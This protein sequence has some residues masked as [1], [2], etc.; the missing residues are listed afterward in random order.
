MTLRPDSDISAIRQHI[1]ALRNASWLDRTRQ[2]W[3]T[4]LFHCT[5]ITNV[6]SILSDGEI[7]SRNRITSAGQLPTDIASPQVIEGTNLKWQDYVRLYFRPRTPTQYRNEGFRPIG[8]REW[9]SHCPVPV[10]LIFNALTVLSRSDSWFSDGNLGSPYA[11]VQ[12][13]VA[14]LKQIPFE[15]VYH[16]S[17]FSRS[18]RGRQIV[19]HRHAEVLVPQSMR[20]DS[21]RLIGCRSDAE[22]KTLLQLLPPETHSRWVSRIGVLSS[23]QLFHQEWTFLEQVDMSAEKIVFRFNRSSRTPGPFDARVEIDEATTGM[24]YRWR[25]EAYQCNQELTLSLSS[26]KDPSDYTARLFLDNQL[27]YADRFH[28]ADLPF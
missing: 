11:N 27:A 16:N 1:D 17:P 28:G 22:Y 15:S 9:N 25:N 23:L 7:Y 20:L 2:W 21:L 10:Y 19:H 26:L 12:R 13:E 6:V 14:F 5:N 18:V 4:C 24:K 3:P 8:Q